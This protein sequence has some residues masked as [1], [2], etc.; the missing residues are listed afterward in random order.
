MP[1]LSARNL[2]RLKSS[3]LPGWALVWKLSRNCFQAYSDCWQNP[4]SSRHRIGV[5]ISLLADGQGL[6]SSSK[7]HLNSSLHGWLYFQASNGTYNLFH[8]SDLSSLSATGQR[9]F[10][11]FRGLVIISGLPIS[12]PFTLMQRQL[13]SNLNHTGKIHCAI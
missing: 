3:C 13:I 7:G 12:F 10:S 11:A 5:P 1:V 4:V 9:K 6:S 8:D 2:T